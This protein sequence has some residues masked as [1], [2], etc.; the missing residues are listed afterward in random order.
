M[1]NLTDKPKSFTAEDVKGKS[2]DELSTMFR[3][4]ALH[5]TCDRLGMNDTEYDAVKKFVYEEHA[6]CGK[7]IKP[8]AGYSYGY[9]LSLTPLN[10][11]TAYEVT[12]TICEQ[13]K[14]VTDVSDW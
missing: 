11:G 7:K 12:C 10:L 14:D 5:Y 9:K 8:C 13:T 2:P 4:N 3:D 6:E 1:S